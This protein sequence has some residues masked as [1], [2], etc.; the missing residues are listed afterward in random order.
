MSD[1]VMPSG[2]VDMNHTEIEYTEGGS[3]FSDWIPYLVF[4]VG[5]T[6]MIVGGAAF[7]GA[8][9]AAGLLI[10]AVGVAWIN[11]FGQS[12]YANEG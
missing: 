10:T 5:L 6:V 1:L 7:G 4:G 2:F 3:C 8:V 12:S 11:N 9:F